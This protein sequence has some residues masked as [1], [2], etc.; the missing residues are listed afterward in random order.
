MNEI[1]QEIDIINQ[2]IYQNN[3]IVSQKNQKQKECHEIIWNHIAFLLQQNT[4]DY[5]HKSDSFRQ[6]IQFLQAQSADYERQINGLAAQISVLTRQM[7]D[8][9]PTIDKMNQLLSHTGFQG[10]YIRKLPIRIKTASQIVRSDGGIAENLS[11][12]EQKFL[13]F[14]YFCQLAYEKNPDRRSSG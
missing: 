5:Y 7:T 8:T 3:Q 11:E 13:A 12:G 14:I 4:D 2:A 9:E 10:F 1:N 6:N